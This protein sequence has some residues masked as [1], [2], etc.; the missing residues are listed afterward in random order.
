MALETV[1]IVSPVSDENPQ[2]FI[3]INKS[4]FGG[5]MVVYKE[6]AS[7]KG[8]AGKKQFDKA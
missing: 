5:D 3:V 7:P 4:D 1:R 2:G 8:D 6:P